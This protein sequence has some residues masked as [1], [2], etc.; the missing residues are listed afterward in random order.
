MLE[1]VNRGYVYGAAPISQEVEMYLYQC[2]GAD[3]KIYNLHV[4]HL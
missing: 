1:I 2:F 3:R 4:A